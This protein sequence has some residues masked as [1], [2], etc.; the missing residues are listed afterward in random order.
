[1]AFQLL[2]VYSTKHFKPLFYGTIYEPH[3]YDQALSWGLRRKIAQ[4]MYG[5]MITESKII[6]EIK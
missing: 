4:A 6:Q 5:A 3:S 1:M 2:P